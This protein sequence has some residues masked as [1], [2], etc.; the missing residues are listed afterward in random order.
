MGYSCSSTQTNFSLHIPSP[1]KS[2][3]FPHL[4]PS[5]ITL[6]FANRRKAPPPPTAL[7]V[8]ARAGFS[9]C[10]PSSS[11]SSS[12]NT[13]LEPCSAAG[14]FLSSV[15]QNQ[16]ELFD[17]A[18]A[19]EL[20]LLADDRNGA[21]S[22]MLLSSRSDEAFL[23]RRIAQL[24]EQ[25][26]QIAVE[27]VMYLLIFSKFSEIKVPLVPKLSRCIYNSRL[28]I[29]PSKDWEL[30]SIHSCEVLEMIREHVCTVIGLRANCSVTDSWATTEIQRLQLG[31]V[32]AASM[33]YGYFLK[34]A[35][36]RHY[37]DTCLAELCDDV[38]L[39]CRTDRQYAESLSQGP[40]NHVFGGV[41]NMQ[42]ASTGLGSNNQ[43]RK[44][45][46][47]RCYVMGFDAETLKRCAK[48]KSK[49]AKHLIGKHT[50]AL[51]GDDE[52]GLLEDDEV[53]LTSFSSLKRLVLEAVAFGSFLWDAED[54][55]DSVFKLS[56]HE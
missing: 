39:S 17:V 46:N 50:R 42:S 21:V 7:F 34:S 55:V 6:N 48:L 10:E 54:Y 33:L 11:S 52:T 30:E 23:H 4:A 8:V 15:F 20:K 19:E 44:C 26:C 24:K 49:E 22:R 37:L 2:I 36:S 40:T 29:G 56:E 9:H 28:E 53:I 31:R 32:Y 35:S 41:S 38:H 25:E 5:H 12:L 51:F 3:H 27:D 43:V 1:A 45:E 47:L 13:P 16:R 14:K 18:V